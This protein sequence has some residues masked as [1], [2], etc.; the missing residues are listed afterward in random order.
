[1]LRG[2]HNEP[3]PAFV[4]WFAVEQI[5]NREIDVGMYRH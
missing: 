1:M 3:D 4:D 2:L 5:Q